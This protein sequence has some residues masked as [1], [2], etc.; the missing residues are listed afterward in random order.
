MKKIYMI[1]K[2]E[3][4]ELETI[5]MLCSSVGSELGGYADS[6]G[7]AREWDDWSDIDGEE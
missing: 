2:A 5:G 1:P 4:I 6:P 7:K 3:V